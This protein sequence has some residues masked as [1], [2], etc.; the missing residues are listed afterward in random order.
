MG[1][2]IAKAIE[3]LS[4]FD[5]RNPV[6]TVKSVA[7]HLGSPVSSTY[8]LINEL[9]D[10]GL[11]E[12]IESGRLVTTEKLWTLGVAGSETLRLRNIALPVME[13]LLSYSRQHTLLSVL[14]GPNVIYLESLKAS[15]GVHS[16]AL[17]GEQMPARI[18]SSGILLAA[19][20]ST[21]VQ[22]T[23][24]DFP[25]D[26]HWFVT[27][28]PEE[29]HIRETNREE[30]VNLM[31]EARRVNSCKLEGWLSRDTVG[32]AVPIRKN[33]V[34]IAALSHIVR[35]DGSTA[36]RC[37]PHLHRAAQEISNTMSERS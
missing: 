8:R 18:N 17:V 35:N 6:Q 13:N 24:L 25:L 15:G 28:P 1:S 21:D 14:R 20:S 33:G 27:N 12:R 2:Q 32:I 19:F 3:V 5:H 10:L 23:V 11:L 37:L 34:V 26:D 30:I 9:I 31:N 4:L 16:L 7:S 22:K 36:L 29:L